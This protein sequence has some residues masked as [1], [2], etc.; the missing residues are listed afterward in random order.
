MAPMCAMVTAALAVSVAAI[1]LRLQKAS[2]V[3][4]ALIDYGPL[5]TTGVWT[6]DFS[7]RGMERFGVGCQGPEDIAFDKHGRLYAGCAD[8]WIK[9]AGADGKFANFSFVGGRPLGLDIGGDPQ[10]LYVADAILGMFEVSLS[11][12]VARSIG[13]TDDEGTIIN[14]ADGVSIASD[15]SVY[16]TDVSSSFGWSNYTLD[17]LESRPN[18]RLLKYDPV[19]KVISVVKRDM[20]FPNGVAIS[21]DGEFA[22]I[23]ETTRARLMRFWLKGE[24][25]GTMD[26]FLDGLPGFPDNVKHQDGKFYVGIAGRRLPLTDWIFNSSFGVQ[27]R[28]IIAQMTFIDILAAGKTVGRLCVVDEQGQ[29]LKKYE[30]PTGKLINEVTGGLRSGSYVYLSSLG[31]PFLGRIKEA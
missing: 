10:V 17:L 31:T 11:D 12:G 27:L 25:K 5:P 3:S 1:V 7:L 16:F 6:S 13:R 26:V 15:G 18:G 23:A 14:F 19:T 29:V 28:S 22:V 2:P 30:D 20:W 4:P 9:R 24:N 21:R 8:G